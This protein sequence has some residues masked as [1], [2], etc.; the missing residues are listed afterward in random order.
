MKETADYNKHVARGIRL[1]FE[2]K[3]RDL[4]QKGRLYK[5]S[6]LTDIPG[7]EFLHPDEAFLCRTAK[8]T[9]DRYSRIKTML[10]SAHANGLYLTP[11]NA[12]EV[13]GESYLLA[14]QVLSL[15]LNHK[16]VNQ[17]PPLFYTAAKADNTYAAPSVPRYVPETPVK[18]TV[19]APMV[20]TR[21]AEKATNAA[22]PGSTSVQ[23]VALMAVANV[24]ISSLRRLPSKRQR[25]C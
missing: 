11:Q 18:R 15:L 7:A 4:N 22:L 25:A 24:P 20:I 10:L 23:I 16:M 6:N 19:P 21:V 14:S 1:V 8:V 17:K 9:P 3:H 13:S 12:V 5:Q 2:E